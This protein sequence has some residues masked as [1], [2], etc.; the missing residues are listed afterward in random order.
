MVDGAVEAVF[1]MFIFGM[2][3][4]RLSQEFYGKINTSNI[5]VCIIMK[6]TMREK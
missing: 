5:L 2:F 1:G 4:F 3:S 6:V